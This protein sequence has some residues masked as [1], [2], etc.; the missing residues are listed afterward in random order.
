MGTRNATTALAKASV[1]RLLTFMSPPPGLTAILSSWYQGRPGGGDMR[2]LAGYGALVCL[3]AVSAS[4]TL[5]DD[6]PA[7]PAGPT[8]PK[9]KQ[10]LADRDAAAKK[11]EDELV[12]KT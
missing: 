11:A 3:V 2:Q 12:A 1:R 8:N 9:A 10:A 5:A 7:K 4:R 6:P